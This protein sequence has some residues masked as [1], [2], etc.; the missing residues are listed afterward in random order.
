MKK[1]NKYIE[2][3]KPKV[4]FLWA[5]LKQ[6]LLRKG[7]GGLV[8]G[9]SL[10]ALITLVVCGTFTYFIPSIQESYI[11]QPEGQEITTVINIEPDYS[12]LASTAEV[13]IT[14]EVLQP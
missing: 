2:A 12:Y 5:R 8:L 6:L 3:L 4:T 9:A 10:V 11:Y 13:I 7:K 1:L 14:V